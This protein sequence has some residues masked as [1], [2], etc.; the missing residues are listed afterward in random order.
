MSV[1]LA[2]IFLSVPSTFNQL[3]GVHERTIAVF[4]FVGIILCSSHKL[5]RK[6]VYQH[7][8]GITMFS[9]PLSLFPGLFYCVHSY[10]YISVSIVVI[11]YC[12][13]VGIKASHLSK[14]V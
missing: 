4:F 13:S 6:E 11:Y 10:L 7:F 2:I 8:V 14:M 12:L 3:T 9:Y 1:V 5:K